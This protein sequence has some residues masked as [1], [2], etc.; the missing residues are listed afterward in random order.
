MA[1]DNEG[2][3]TQRIKR[4]QSEKYLKIKMVQPDK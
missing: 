3:G 2:Q 4:R 1:R